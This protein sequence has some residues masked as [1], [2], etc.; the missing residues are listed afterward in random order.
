MTH[1][2]IRSLIPVCSVTNDM[3][4][5]PRNCPLKRRFQC[6]SR[7]YDNQIDSLHPRHSKEYSEYGI[8]SV[9]VD[10]IYVR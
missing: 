4:R 7:V 6:D 8:E 10:T 5:Y 1:N 2:N 9:Y 3:C